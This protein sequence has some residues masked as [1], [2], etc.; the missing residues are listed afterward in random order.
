MNAKEFKDLYD[1]LKSKGRFE[2]A[3]LIRRSHNRKVMRRE[4]QPRICVGVGDDEYYCQ[5][6]A[7]NDGG[8]SWVLV[9]PRG[10]DE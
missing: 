10:K 1:W 7:V 5:E 2:E 6:G 9:P 4:T 8:R 3:N